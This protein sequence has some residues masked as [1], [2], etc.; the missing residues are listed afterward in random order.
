MKD[1]RPPVLESPVIKRLVNVLLSLARATPF[2]VRNE[3][4]HM[5]L[6]S[7]TTFDSSACD[8]KVVR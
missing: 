4:C 3:Q 5:R 6:M 1:E 8:D 7:E 2:H